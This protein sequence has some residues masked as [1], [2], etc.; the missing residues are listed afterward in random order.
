M[1]SIA[2]IFT[3]EFPHSEILG[4][5]YIDNSPRLIA[6]Y[7][8][9]HRLLTPRHPPNALTLF[10]LYFNFNIKYTK[11]QIIYRIKFTYLFL[12]IYII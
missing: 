5:K 12:F 2:D 10:L 6:V 8:V 1:Y 3:D 11:A 4:S 7:H 9:F